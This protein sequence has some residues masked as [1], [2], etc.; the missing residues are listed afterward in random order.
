MQPFPTPI[1][2]QTNFVTIGPQVVELFKFE[3]VY[4]LTD[5]DTRTHSQTDDGSTGK[6]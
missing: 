2:V 4:R 1:M 5:T 6:L 3:N